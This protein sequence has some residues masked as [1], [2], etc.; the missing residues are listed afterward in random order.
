VQP[1]APAGR[2]DACGLSPFPMSNVFMAGQ[3]LVRWEVTAC[4]DEGPYRLTIRH[5]HG[6][7]VEYFHTVT[8]ALDRET[9]LE[10]LLIAARGGRPC[11]FGKVA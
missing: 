8:D 5:R 1:R 10:E 2:H 7:I 9:E 4:G 3:E 6:S 11:R